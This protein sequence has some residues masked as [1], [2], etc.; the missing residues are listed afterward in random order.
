MKDPKEKEVRRQVG[1]LGLWFVELVLVPSAPRKRGDQYRVTIL[2][3][4]EAQFETPAQDL[5]EAQLIFD[6][7]D[8][9]LKFTIQGVAV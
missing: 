8:Q 7:L 1:W 6:T 3:N 5:L 4:G 9:R 2:A